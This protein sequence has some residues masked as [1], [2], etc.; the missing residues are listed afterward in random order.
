MR[1]KFWTALIAA[2]LCCVALAQNQDTETDFEGGYGST[3]TTIG[4]NIQTN[5]TLTVDGNST[6]TGNVTVG[7]VLS[8]GSTGF[9]S[10]SINGGHAGAGSTLSSTGDGIFKYLN[11]QADGM[12]I[13]AGGL[14]VT[15][16]TVLS[17]L[18]L[19]GTSQTD[20]G[21]W[22]VTYGSSTPLQLGTIS[23]ATTISAPSGS[24][25]SG[26][27]LIYRVKQDG[28]GG[29]TISWNAIFRFNGWNS[30]AS[31]AA[32][33][34]DYWAFLYNA[35]DTKWDCIFASKP[36]L[37]TTGNL[38]VGGNATITGNTTVTGNVA[39]ADVSASDDLTVTDDASIGDDLT[40]TGD[41]SVTGTTFTAAGLALM[42]DASATAQR[43]TLGLTIG[44]NVQAYDTELAAIA[45]LTS[46]ANKAPVFTGS[47]TASTI[48]VESGRSSSLT[49]T[50]ITNVS[51][52]T[53][54]YCQYSR[55]G[56]IVTCS[57]RATVTPTAGS[58]TLTEF[59]LDL[60]FTSNLTGSSDLFG[61]GV[62]NTSSPYL[63]AYV[64][65]DSGDTARIRF[66]APGT[67]AYGVFVTFQYIIL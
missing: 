36:N 7:G 47:G 19:S 63:A 37:E 10:L 27:L 40:V 57:V 3:G 58:A 25:S 11:V 65:G 20:D 59:S 34:I 18:L 21:T 41:L 54:S 32:N 1:T 13:S 29:R 28:T 67:S 60:P 9:T 62:V 8:A 66:Y 55:V 45:G 24:P 51:T 33:A 15:G 35:T 48:H 26:A 43:T 6:L 16:V 61:S 49:V 44:T 64:F 12:D 17:D 50:G 22:A 4:G 39:G 14:A 5:G 2:V 42:D 56:D 23:Q 30:V 46:A 52:V 53:L 31:T 38:T